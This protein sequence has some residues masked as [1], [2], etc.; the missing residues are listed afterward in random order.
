MAETLAQKVKKKKKDKGSV[1]AL[2]AKG[3]T[4]RSLQTGRC[5]LAR[6]PVLESVFRRSAAR[7]NM[8]AAVPLGHRNAASRSNTDGRPELEPKHSR[9]SSLDFA[10]IEP[11]LSV[12]H[13]L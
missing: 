12:G 8:W 9:V 5:T 4:N 1:D 10:R 6:P 13:C 2:V 11:Y 7:G 3:C